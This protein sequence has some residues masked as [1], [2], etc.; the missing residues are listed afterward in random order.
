VNERVPRW[1]W[2]DLPEPA[3]IDDP[4]LAGR[5]RFVASGRHGQRLET[6]FDARVPDP[7][8]EPSA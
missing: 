8:A 1:R 5:G 6:G 7:V 3:D 2:T 4:P